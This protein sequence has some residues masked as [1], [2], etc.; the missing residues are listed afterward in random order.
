MRRYSKTFVLALAL[1]ATAVLA[2]GASTA[3]AQGGGH[4]GKGL[5][6]VSTTT[7]GVTTTQLNTA[8]PDA[9]KALIVAKIDA[10]VEDGDLTADEAA[11]LKSQL[12]DATL[13]GHK[14][15]S[16]GGLGFGGQEGPGGG[17]HH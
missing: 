9:R 17:R 5:G 12:D 14:A 6:A 15:S 3:A 4:R 16:L 1:G 13:P 11:D 8:F 2:V 10:A 7:L